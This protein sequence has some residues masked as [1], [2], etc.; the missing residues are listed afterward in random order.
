MVKSKLT[1]RVLVESAFMIALASVLSMIKVYEA[2]YGGSVTLGSMI[3]ILY[4]ALR[5]GT[6]VGLFA[7]IV[8]GLVQLVLGPYVVHPVQ[9]LL[10]YPIAFGLLGLA[11]LTPLRPAAGAA[12]GVGGRFIAH[13][14]AGVVFFAHFAPEGLSPALYSALYNGTYL[15]PELV[16][17][18][19][20][21][22]LL[23]PLLQKTRGRG[24]A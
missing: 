23:L 19:V 9:F 12:L 21:L 13:W 3:P 15:L 6:G 4:L 8:Y 7:G 17:S 24:R 2:P 18:T 20:V 1:T 10:D 16:V 22:W 5:H 14:L 11:G